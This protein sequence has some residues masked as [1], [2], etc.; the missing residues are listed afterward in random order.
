[1]LGTCIQAEVVSEDTSALL[2]QKLCKIETEK[3]LKSIAKNTIYIN[4]ND[5]FPHVFIP[6]GKRNS[7]QEDQSK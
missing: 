5:I 4:N 7:K 6:S 1:M 3:K 2:K